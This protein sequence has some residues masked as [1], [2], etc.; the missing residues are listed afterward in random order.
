[1]QKPLSELLDSIIEE[2]LQITLFAVTQ[3]ITCREALYRLVE[4]VGDCSLMRLPQGQSS[5]LRLLSFNMLLTQ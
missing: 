3:Q 4:K 5:T 1:M 2:P